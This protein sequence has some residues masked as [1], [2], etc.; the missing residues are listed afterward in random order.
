[1]QEGDAF[2]PN[3]LATAALRATDVPRPGAPW[4]PDVS[5]FALTFDGYVY[6]GGLRAC[7][8]ASE[9]VR[10]HHLAS[11]TLVEPA[12]SIGH[13]ASRSWGSRL[14]MRSRTRSRSARVK[15]QENGWASRR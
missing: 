7:A 15:V 8:A 12:G 2:P 5:T 13:A 1:M 14:A 11:R 6:L 9:L 10:E 4:W 3:A